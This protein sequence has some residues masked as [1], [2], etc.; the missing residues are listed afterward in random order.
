M[1]GRPL[2]VVGAGIAKSAARQ[3]CPQERPNID[4]RPQPRN[5]PKGD[6]LIGLRARDDACRVSRAVG[7]ARRLLGF[8]LGQKL[9]DRQPLCIV[10]RA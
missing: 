4:R 9:F 7:R 2:R 3:L 5:A 6:S 8:R 1:H 10:E